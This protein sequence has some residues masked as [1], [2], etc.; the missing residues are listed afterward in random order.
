MNHENDI[1]YEELYIL[2]GVVIACSQIY[3]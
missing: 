1:M 2:L 3:L